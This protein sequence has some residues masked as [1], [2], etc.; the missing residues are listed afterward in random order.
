MNLEPPYVSHYLQVSNLDDM[1]DLQ[2]MLAPSPHK[3]MVQDS[4]TLR[5]QSGRSWKSCKHACY[6]MRLR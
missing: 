6:H 2:E 4:E 1:G 3:H 5:E